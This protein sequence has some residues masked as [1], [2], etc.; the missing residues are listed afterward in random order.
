MVTYEPGVTARAEDLEALAPR[1][2]VGTLGA[3]AEPPAG[4]ALYVSCGDPEARA[5]SGRVPDLS[6][7]RALLVNAAEARLLTGARTAEEAL[8]RL[9]AGAPTVVVTLGSRG[10]TAVIEGREV[11][12]AAVDGG[13]AIDTTGAGD[14]FVAAY[15]W[16]DLR[17]AAPEA[18]VRWAT[19]YA[20][21]SV[22]RP[23]GTGGAVTEARLIEEGTRL[24]L[25]RHP[26][27]AGHAS[28][29][30]SPMEG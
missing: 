17:G 10:A 2:V 20:A 16:A 18:R 24:G 29:T 14:L 11:T 28:S 15:I 27:P 13:P 8:Q 3:V 30:P 7:A 4:A 23:T 9:A 19:L 25:P 12:A 1:A 21:L 22:T 6:G 26:V 5:H